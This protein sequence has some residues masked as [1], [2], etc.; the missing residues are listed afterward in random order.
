M[1]KLLGY[2]YKQF[3]EN[4]LKVFMISVMAIVIAITELLEPYLLQTLL[5]YGIGEKKINL[6]YIISGVYLFIIIGKNILKY[7]VNYITIRIKKSFS[8]NIKKEIL[9]HT[10]KIPGEFYSNQK[11][12]EFLKVIESDVSALE[13]VGI[14]VIINM[15]INIVSAI[16]AFIILYNLNF[17]LLTGIILLEIIMMIFQKVFIKYI[18]KQTSNVRNLMGNSMSILEEYLSNIMNAIMTKANK[19]FIQKY[20]N[21]EENVIEKSCGLEN[22]MEK[23]QL[24]A[25][26][27]NECMLLLTYIVGGIWV[28][29]GRMTIGEIIAFSQYIFL[30]ITPIMQLI[31]LNAKIQVGIVSVKKI[32]ETKSIPV[33]KDEGKDYSILANEIELKDIVFL[34]TIGEPILLNI[35]MKF[36]KGKK[37]AI[38]GKSGGG[39]ST[40]IKLLYR[41]WEPVDGKILIDGK[42]IKDYNLSVLRNSIA[43]VTQDTILFD[44]TIWNNISLGRNFTKKEIDL[45]CKKTE[46]DQIINSLNFGYQTVVGERG[47]KLS[48]G[49]K[50]RIILARALL[51]KTPIIILD[52][53]TSALDNIMQKKI[54]R[55]IEDILS[56][57][58][59]IMITHRMST[60]NESDYIYLLEE[61][62]IKEEGIHDDLRNQ[63][64]E[65]TKMLLHEGC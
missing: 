1:V 5:D 25:N 64:G 49:Q 36:T 40:L 56:D 38:I 18:A 20:L 45:I 15:A 39:K 12:G 19:N 43:I 42:D 54:L 60:I 37:I 21:N 13:S 29:K 26:G 34:Y 17:K 7:I 32:E 47:I 35:S 9:S 10:E 6:L 28:I 61:N 11:T 46:L 48:G 3:C 41:L 22:L 30:L 50:Q 14:D 8:L 51:Q 57:R 4:K 53:A 27:I 63:G 24:L 59:T 16:I 2:I 58:I 31:N 23:N 55:N 62:V 65:Y 33:I 52:E 44:D